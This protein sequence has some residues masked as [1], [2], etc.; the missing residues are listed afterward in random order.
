M[1]PCVAF[2][3]DIASILRGIP[4][5]LRRLAEFR[6]LELCTGIRLNIFKTELLPIGVTEPTCWKV[7]LEDALPAMHEAA[8]IPIVQAVRYLGFRIGRGNLHFDWQMLDKLVASAEQLTAFQYGSL[9]NLRYCKIL[10]GMM[11]YPLAVGEASTELTKAWRNALS[12]MG[13]TSLKLE[14][15][16]SCAK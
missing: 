13:I 3:D 6:E 8:M 9:H 12:R 16:L 10:E 15:L 7:L 4:E 2:A 11:A 5:L 14:G 1:Y